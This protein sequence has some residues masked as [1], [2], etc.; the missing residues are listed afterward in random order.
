M[1]SAS[2]VSE[3]RV[4]ESN[5]LLC[6]SGLTIEKKTLTTLFFLLSIKYSTIFPIILSLAHAA[7]TGAKVVKC[8]GSAYDLD[9]VLCDA[10]DANENAI[11]CDP[12]Q[13][14]I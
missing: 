5:L 14:Q 11:L 6:H 1:T 10:H 12:F 8:H 9:V 2:A 13:L 7:N 3:S 4:H